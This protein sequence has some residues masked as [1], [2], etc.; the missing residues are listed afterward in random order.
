MSTSGEKQYSIVGYTT[1]YNFY[2]YPEK[3]RKRISQFLILPPF[4]KQRH[5]AELLNALY[6][7]YRGNDKVKDLTVEE[8]SLPFS[9]LRNVSD[10]LNI[11]KAELFQDID[12]IKPIEE[13]TL[14]AV[15]TKLKLAPDQIKI[16]YEIFLLKNTNMSD[17]KEAKQYRLF[18]KRRLYKKYQ[19]I[20][21]GFE[22]IDERKK[23]LQKKFMK[24]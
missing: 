18:I 23:E 4:Q 1:V 21:S 17:E 15:R 10:A 22:N 13:D 19:D 7:L 5:G 16:M 24:R 11:Q 20:L 12:E 8:P 2:S 6:D 9:H 3:I 14:K